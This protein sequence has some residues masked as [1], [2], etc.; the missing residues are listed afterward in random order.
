MENFLYKIFVLLPYL[1][2]R[3]NYRIVFWLKL[4]VPNRPPMHEKNIFS[5]RLVL[6]CTIKGSSPKMGRHF[7][8]LLIGKKYEN[9]LAMA[10]KHKTGLI[11]LLGMLGLLCFEVYLV[12]FSW[13]FSRKYGRF[14]TKISAVTVC[15]KNFVLL[16][17]LKVRK[18]FIWKLLCKAVWYSIF[19][20]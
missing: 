18:F 10:L 4:F 8:S 2:G 7:S 20:Q 17:I 16:D 9:R 14:C 3:K 19:V 15:N 1:K 5:I 6:I 11:D 12:I 13:I